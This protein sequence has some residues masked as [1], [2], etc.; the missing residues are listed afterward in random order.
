MLEAGEDCESVVELTFKMVPIKAS[1]TF[2][3]YCFKIGILK[4]HRCYFLESNFKPIVAVNC[5]A[6]ILWLADPLPFPRT[7]VFL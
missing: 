6:N 4:K 7:K 1:K 5:P 2:F 3:Y